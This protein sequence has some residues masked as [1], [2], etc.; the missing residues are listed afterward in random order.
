[1]KKKTKQY[2]QDWWKV[3]GPSGVV[4][5]GEDLLWYNARLLAVAALQVSQDVLELERFTGVVPDG[6]RVIVLDRDGSPR[7]T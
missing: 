2:A 6:A 3:S 7:M 4:F 1:M 5:V